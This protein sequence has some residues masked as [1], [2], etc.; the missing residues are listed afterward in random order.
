[1]I[2][3]KPVKQVGYTKADF[4]LFY[5][6]H[7]GKYINDAITIRISGVTATACHWI[8]VHTGLFQ[9]TAQATARGPAIPT[10]SQGEVITERRD[11]IERNIQ[12]LILAIGIGNIAKDF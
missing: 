7:R 1:M 11:L 3:V 12:I 8:A 2:G 5:K 6:L 9:G 4:G 10:V